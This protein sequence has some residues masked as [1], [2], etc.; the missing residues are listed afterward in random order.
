[1]NFIIRIM[2]ILFLTAFLIA[3][4]TGEEFTMRFAGFM[5]FMIFGYAYVCYESDFQKELENDSDK[6]TQNEVIQYFKDNTNE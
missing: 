2:C 5:G 3:A 6:F 1:M 4:V